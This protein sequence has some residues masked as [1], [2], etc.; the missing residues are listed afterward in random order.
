[1]EKAI[2][3]ELNIIKPIFLES[4]YTKFFTEGLADCVEQI[5]ICEIENAQEDNDIQLVF[6]SVWFLIN[7]FWPIII[8]IN[9]FR[10]MMTQ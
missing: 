6:N 4:T 2:E 8:K 9:I 3:T 1:M 5:Q 7:N 10:Q